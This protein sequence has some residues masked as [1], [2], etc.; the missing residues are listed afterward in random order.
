MEVLYWQLAV[1]GSTAAAY[2]IGSRR[3]ALAVAV[4]WTIWTIAQL[5]YGPLIVIQLISAWG[6]F[7]AV[8]AVTAQSRQL[9]KLERALQGYRNDDRQA[10]IRAR[11]EGKVE[12]LT[13]SDHYSYMLSEIDKAES[14][15]LILSGWISDRVVDDRFIQTLSRALS[16]GVKVFLGFGYEDSKGTHDLSEPGKRALRA[17]ASVQ[18]RSP[19]LHVGKFNNHQK[20]MVIDKRRVVCGSH[21]WLSNRAFKNR[22]RSFIIGDSDAAE[23]VFL[24][25]VG[26]VKDHPVGAA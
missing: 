6:T 15:V 11:R 7:F 9:R 1:A 14:T 24:H 26:L 10:I 20:V 5:G 23:S 25:S 16:R 3:W 18:E 17:L 21:N 19:D 12:P 4:L 2:L 8:D 13:D 22:E